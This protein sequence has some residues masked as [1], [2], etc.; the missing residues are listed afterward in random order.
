MIHWVCDRKQLKFGWGLIRKRFKFAVLNSPSSLREI[1]LL[2]LLVDDWEE[3]DNWDLK[4]TLKNEEEKPP[5]IAFT[6]SC[7]KS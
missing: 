4:L 7:L 3:G 1:E 2:L 5:L 6:H